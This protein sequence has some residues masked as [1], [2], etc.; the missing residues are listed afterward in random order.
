MDRLDYTGATVL[1]GA[2]IGGSGR[3][4]ADTDAHG[5]NDTLTYTPGL[6]TG[7]TNSSGRTLT[8]AYKPEEVPVY[9][10]PIPGLGRVSP[11]GVHDLAENAGWVSVGIDYDRPGGD[12]LSG[13]W[14]LPDR[15][16]TKRRGHGQPAH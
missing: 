13:Y 7:D 4:L 16:H 3:Y 1:Y 9:D 15:H 11:Y 6:P 2:L 8:M 5:N 10:F 14:H 12:Q